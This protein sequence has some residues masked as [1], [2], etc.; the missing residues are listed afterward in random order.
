[1]TL[2]TSLVVLIIFIAAGFDSWRDAL[3]NRKGN[4]GYWAFHLVKWVAYY[5]TLIPLVLEHLL[6]WLLLPVVIGA[7]LVWFVMR[8]L[9]LKRVGGGFA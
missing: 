5:S 1:M 7:T 8:S 4:V 6:N 2:P 9:V 3:I